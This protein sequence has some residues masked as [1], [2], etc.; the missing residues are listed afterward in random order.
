M[1]YIS[2]TGPAM[3]IDENGISG[4][5]TPKG[6]RLTNRL[7]KKKDNK[8]LKRGSDSDSIY[9]TKSEK[10]ATSEPDPRKLPI[11]P[12]DQ[13]VDLP[14][15]EVSSDADES[16]LHSDFEDHDIEPTFSSIDTNGGAHPIIEKSEKKFLRELQQE[17]SDNWFEEK[18]A[19]REHE[20]KIRAAKQGKKISE[21]AGMINAP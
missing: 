1:T 4:E 9:E 17:F 13:Y 14:D 7:T 10:S 6:P 20:R 2:T 5:Q 19:Q 18:L 15:A 12:L 3:N 8:K 16:M 21:E 11:K